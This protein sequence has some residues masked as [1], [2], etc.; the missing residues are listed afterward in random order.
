MNND[1]MSSNTLPYMVSLILTLIL[2]YNHFTN[3]LYKTSIIIKLNFTF[4]FYGL[5]T[6][7]SLNYNDLFSAN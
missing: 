5:F 3:S 4:I 6:V 7:L 2:F 1:V